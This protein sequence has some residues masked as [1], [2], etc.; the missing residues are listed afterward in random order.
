MN[1]HEKARRGS[2]LA[3]SDQDVYYAFWI[4]SERMQRV[5]TLAR[6]VAPSLRIRIVCRFGSEIFCDLLLAWDTL[7]PV[8][9]PLPQIS[10]VRGMTFLRRFI[11]KPAASIMGK[12]AMQ[13]KTLKNRTLGET[14][15]DLA[16]QYLRDQGFEVVA[17]NVRSPQGELDIVAARKGE[18]HFVE[19]RSRTS[20]E[21]LH[22]FETIT[23]S[24]KKKI[25]KTAM[26]YLMKHR[27]TMKDVDVPACYFDV[28]GVDF[29]VNPPHI[30]CLL[31]AFTE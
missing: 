5:Q 7:R 23:E 21:F 6:M 11:K 2:L 18:L 28:I 16:A 4:A 10:Q 26:W 14:G 9:R 17:R 15:E 13:E 24:K 8:S 3:F 22:P 25:R 31:D 19:V 29:S 12:G 30:E 27:K 20:S 1:K